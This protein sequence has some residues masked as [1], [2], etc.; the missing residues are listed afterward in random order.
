MNYLPIILIVVFLLSNKNSTENALP[1]DLES[2][3]P[4]LSL[5]GVSPQISE[6]LSSDAIK[7]VLSG[8]ADIKSLLPVIT[9]LI[10]SL[11]SSAPTPTPQAEE[12]ENSEFFN[13]IK[14]VAEDKILSTLGNYFEN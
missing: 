5:F 11:K 13:P 8:N 2:I 12:S 6:I 1:F 7:N 9:S 10:T 14:D 4:L 3:T